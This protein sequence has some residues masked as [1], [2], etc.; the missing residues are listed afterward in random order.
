MW[1]RKLVEF[2][3]IRYAQQAT[4]YFHLNTFQQIQ[5]KIEPINILDLVTKED[6]S[7]I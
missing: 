3:D 2:Y 4:A 5:F 6:T 7:Y 1:I